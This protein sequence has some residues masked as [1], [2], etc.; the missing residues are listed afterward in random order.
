M[1]LFNL[2]QQNATSID[3]QLEINNYIGILKKDDPTRITLTSI[4][5][6]IENISV[7]MKNYRHTYPA[8]DL[9]RS[10]TEV[11]ILIQLLKT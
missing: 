7:K 9:R 11:N 3:Q 5:I 2:A 8:D 1:N 6:F 4:K 10:L